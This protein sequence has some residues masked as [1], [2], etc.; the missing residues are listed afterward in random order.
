MSCMSLGEV[1]C[2]ARHTMGKVLEI[3]IHYIPDAP[4]GMLKLMASPASQTKIKAFSLFSCLDIVTL[5]KAQP[6]AASG[7]CSQLQV[8]TGTVED[9]RSMGWWSSGVQN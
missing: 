3:C 7:L 4:S 9:R 8:G 5:G 1:C 2:L 6:R